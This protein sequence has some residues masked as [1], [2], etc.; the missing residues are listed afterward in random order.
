MTFQGFKIRTRFAS[1]VVGVDVDGGVGCFV[2][3][4]S[5]GVMT[6]SFTPAEA[7]AVSQALFAVLQGLAAADELAAS[8][9][10]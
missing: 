4:G 1:V 6:L 2:D 8:K 3:Q 7:R 5:K 10:G 9:Q